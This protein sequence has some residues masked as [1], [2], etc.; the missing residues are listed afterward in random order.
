VCEYT[1]LAVHTILVQADTRKD[2]ERVFRELRSGEQQHDYVA[3]DTDYQPRSFGRVV[4][5]DKKR[6]SAKARKP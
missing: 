6:L 4:R 2:A 3:I 5:E 1:S